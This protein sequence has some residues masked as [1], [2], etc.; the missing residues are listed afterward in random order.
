MPKNS[1]ILK[2]FLFA[3]FITCC[4]SQPA[5]GQNSVSVYVE[6]GTSNTV[7]DFNYGIGAEVAF[8]LS[9]RVVV[10]GGIH[11]ANQ[12]PSGFG[13][14]KAGAVVFLSKNTERWSCQNIVQFSSYA[15]YPMNQI[16]YRLLFAWDT[17]HFRIDL[18]NAFTLFTGSGVTKYNLFRP[19]FCFTGRIWDKENPWNI[20]LFIR[21]YDRFE[22][23]GSRCV[24]WG[25]NLS[26][27]IGVKWKIFCEPYV[28]T[29][30]NFNATATF[31]NFNCLIGG[32]YT[33]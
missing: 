11:L 8:K 15:P 32:T 18:G 1:P 33:W 9:Q 4:I 12:Y 20:E 30:G 22:S 27:R 14:V 3:L 26:A 2:N 17:K 6:P 29:V 31:Y 23:H 10:S 16:Y 25:G 21:N 13:S 19:S 28:M 7:N 5:A 24:E